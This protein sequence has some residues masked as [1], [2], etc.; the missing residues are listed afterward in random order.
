M[1]M[2]VA[3]SMIPRRSRGGRWQMAAGSTAGPAGSRQGPG[4][5]RGLNPQGAKAGTGAPGGNFAVRKSGPNV[6]DAR[7]RTV[8][9]A[10]L[11]QPQNCP[12]GLRKALLPSTK[13]STGGT[14]RHHAFAAPQKAPVTP[15]R[16]AGA[17]PA[18]GLARGCLGSLP[19]GGHRCSLSSSPPPIQHLHQQPN[20]H[21]RRRYFH[22]CHLR[23]TLHSQLQIR[24][25]SRS[26]SLNK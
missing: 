13:A 11:G 21:H 17:L 16:A 12:G 26:T 1:G 15:G 8:A 24:Q 18:A 3:P 9:P 14:W 4:G 10:S 7:A 20:R 6:C 22:R 2:F 23:S 25:Y 19:S 5:G